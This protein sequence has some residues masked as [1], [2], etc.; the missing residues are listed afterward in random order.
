MPRPPNKGQFRNPR[1]AH[2]CLAPDKRLTKPREGEE[3]GGGGGGGGGGDEERVKKTMTVVKNSNQD[4]YSHVFICF[5]FFLSL[6]F[7]VCIC[8]SRRNNVWQK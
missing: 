6:T 1:A 4:I 7:G 5:C 8:M 2:H 3:G